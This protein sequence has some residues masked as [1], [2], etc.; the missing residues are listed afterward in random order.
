MSRLL[1][2][3]FKRANIDAKPHNWRHILMSG[4]TS[5]AGMG[6]LAALHFHA[7]DGSDL[8]LM[9]GSFGASAVLLYAL[10][11]AELSQPRNVIGGH[12]VSAAIGI[13]CSKFL[14]V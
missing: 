2:Q 6:S 8:T 9:L 12:L 13:T 5:F 3:W 14:M 4:A 10:P 7:F 1:A 11:D